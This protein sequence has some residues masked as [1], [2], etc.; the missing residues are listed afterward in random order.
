MHWRSRQRQKVFLSY[1][2]KDEKYLQEFMPYLKSLADRWLIDAWS[3]KR[4]EP[5][6]RWHDEI[7]TAIDSAA[8]AVLLVSQDFLA[9]DYIR[10]YEVPPLLRAREE[11]KVPV[12]CLFLK[13]S[14]V[15]HDEMA[16]DAGPAKETVRLMDYQG[17]NDPQ[18][19]LSEMDESERAKTYVAAA[20]WLIDAVGASFRPEPFR[21]PAP[22]QRR[23]LGIRLSVARGYLERSYFS[24]G[25]RITQ[26][27]SP[28]LPLQEQLKPWIS[29]GPYALQPDFDS[30]EYIGGVD[31]DLVA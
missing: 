28:W 23:D 10:D 15:G 26:H 18:R 17:L 13:P 24:G 9:S 30:S 8:V 25:Y 19:P 2:H 1:S 12:A 31:T 22:E 3:D 6:E 4:I 29:Q 21:Q 16:F 27:R 5:S 7:R 11:E 20:E 14:L